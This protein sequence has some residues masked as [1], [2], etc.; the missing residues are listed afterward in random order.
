M[1]RKKASFEGP[2]DLGEWDTSITDASAAAAPRDPELESGNRPDTT[3]EVAKAAEPAPAPTPPAAD[4]VPEVEG[5]GTTIGPTLIVR[6]RLKSR[7]N[8]VVFGRI[9]ASVESTRD[10]RLEAGGIVNADLDVRSVWIGG[11][12][13]GDIRAADLV[14]LAPGARVVGDIRTPRLILHDGAAFRGRVDMDGLQALEIVKPPAYVA[15]VPPKAAPKAAPAPEPVAAEPPAAAPAPNTP[16]VMLE[17]ETPEP[18]PTAQ[19]PSAATVPPAAPRVPTP[20]PAPRASVKSETAPPAPK[21]EQTP[22]LKLT[23]AAKPAEKP[24]AGTGWFGRRS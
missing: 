20:T 13:V 8:L 1:A 6:G 24:A 12:V 3:A 9:E 5:A 17:P 4:P 11:I 7:E 2:Q 22:P 18:A 15:P 10:L 23:P 19:P 21:V 16:T 14:E